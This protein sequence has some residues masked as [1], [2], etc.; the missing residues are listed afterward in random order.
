[1]V[2]NLSLGKKSL[3]AHHGQ[4]QDAL[5]RL[6]ELRNQLSEQ[7]DRDA[8]SYEAVLAAMRKPK[9][10]E[11]EK[12]ERARAI[13][14]ASKSAALVPLATAEMASEIRRSIQEL[15]GVTFAGAASDLAVAQAMAQA[16][17]TGAVENVRA[18]LPSIHDAQWVAEIKTKLVSLGN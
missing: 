9:A 13:E 17:L 8:A 6:S 11:D 10:S 4:L 1:M 5:R 2:C 3:A 12:A 14:E 7:V 15:G 16:A 18:N